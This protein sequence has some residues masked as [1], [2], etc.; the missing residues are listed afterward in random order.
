MLSTSV[1]ATYYWFFKSK[2]LEQNEFFSANPDLDLAREIWNMLESRYLK[3]VF[4]KTFAY[5]GVS[6][7]I[8]LPMTDTI[9]T[10]DN[11]N[12]LPKHYYYHNLQFST[13]L[14]RRQSFDYKE[15][16]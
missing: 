16:K 12:N 8:Y 13:A 11:I 1:Y 4:A 7:K 14:T 10:G 6:K 5:I 2:R 9:M 3:K 15:L